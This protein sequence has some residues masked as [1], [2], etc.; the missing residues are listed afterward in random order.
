MGSSGC[1]AEP[2][3]AADGLQRLLLPRIIVALFFPR[4]RLSPV[5]YTRDARGNAPG[6]RCTGTQ[7]TNQRRVGRWPGSFCTTDGRESL[8]VSTVAHLIPHDR[9]EKTTDRRRCS[10]PRDADVHPHKDIVNPEL[11]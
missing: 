1:R 5:I 8:A 4:V 2:R 9:Q 3:P 11:V 6:I 10:S 7:Y